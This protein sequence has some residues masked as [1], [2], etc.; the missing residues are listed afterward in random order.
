VGQSW[1]G[2][3]ED[4]EN[5]WREGEQGRGEKVKRRPKEREM[6]VEKRWRIGW[7]ACEKKVERRW[8][9]CKKEV[10]TT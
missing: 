10:D 2:I 6:E 5:K 1:R 3:E 9:G 8:R 4:V 7:G